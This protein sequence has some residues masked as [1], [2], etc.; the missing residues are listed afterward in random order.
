MKTY[1]NF[2]NGQYVD[3]KDGRTIP[4]VDPT[5]GEQYATA[6]NSGAADVDA[7]MKAADTAFEGWRDSTPKDRSLALFR[8]ADAIEARAEEFIALESENC[9]KPVGIT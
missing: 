7:A 1:R 9:G 8:I 2:V 6:P 3:A 5:T 4:V